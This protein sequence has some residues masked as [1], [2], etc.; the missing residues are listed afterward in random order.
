MSLHTDKPSEEATAP[1]G[2]AGYLVRI[3]INRE[4]YQSPDPTT[5]EALYALGLV[6]K[7]QELF[8]ELGG[9]HEDDPR[10]YPEPGPQGHGHHQGF[11]RWRTLPR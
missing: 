1:K 8:H 3:H 10:P 11:P 9:N 5:G 6:P 2:G 4:P 7:H